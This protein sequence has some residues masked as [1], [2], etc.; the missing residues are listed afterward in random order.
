MNVKPLLILAMTVFLNSHFSY[1]DLALYEALFDSPWAK[2]HPGQLPYSKCYIGKLHRFDLAKRIENRFL[3]H[4]AP[5][6]GGSSAGLIFGKTDLG[7]QGHQG[8]FLS[9][10][11][12]ELGYAYSI[13]ISMGNLK[14]IGKIGM[15]SAAFRFEVVPASLD[16]KSLNDLY[17]K[18]SGVEAGLNLWV[19]GVCGGKFHNKKTAVKL[20]MKGLS[21]GSLGEIT[22]GHTWFKV[23]PRKHS[24]HPSQDGPYIIT[25]RTVDQDPFPPPFLIQSKNGD[26]WLTV[27]DGDSLLGI[28][29]GKANGQKVLNP[30]GMM[31][32]DGSMVT[33][34]RWDTLQLRRRDGSVIIQDTIKSRLLVPR[35]NRINPKLLGELRFFRDGAR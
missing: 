32:P 24:L 9:C 8:L 5:F 10:I 18:F 23:E 14:T 1:G 29:V 12:N 16:G 17:G 7:A 34:Y 15:A 35:E 6:M 28:L 27:V 19:A 4:P 26:F 20:T 13:P 25:S 30:V 2:E 31:T 11:S 21:L 22:L 3:D 33:N